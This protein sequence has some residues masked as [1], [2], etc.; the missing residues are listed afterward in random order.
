MSITVSQQDSAW[1]TRLA[2]LDEDARYAA[3]D[4]LQATLADVWTRMH[5][6][7]PRESVV[8]VP[9]MNVDRLAPRASAENQAM[10]ERFLFLL[11]LLRQPRLRLVY[12]TSMP[13]DPQIIEYYLSLLPGVIPSHA[14]SRLS[15]IAV[16]DSSSQPLT[17]KLLARPRVLAEIAT[18]VPDRSRCHLIPYIGTTRERDLSLLLG[19]PMYAADPRL[20]DLGTKS[21][22]RA[23]FA[24]AGV[25][26]PAGSEDLHTVS[27]LVGALVQLHR[28]RP[29]SGWAM[30]K[31]NEG[32][33]GSGNAIVD[34]RGVDAASA[35]I[36]NRVQAMQL[37]DQQITLTAYL[38]RLEERGGIVE[39]RMVGDEIRSPSVQMRVT[40][41]GE[42][43]IISTHDQILGGP[44][45]Q[46]YRGARFPA[47]PAYAATITRSAA[48]VGRLLA[49][50]GMLGRFAVDFIVV[51]HGDE[52]KSHAIEVNLRKGGTTHPYLTL[53]FLTDGR[54]DHEQARFITPSGAERYLVATDHLEDDALRGMRIADLF[55]VVARADLHFDQARQSGIVFHMI[56]SITERGQV[57]MT[58]IADS[59]A[60]AQH[61]FDRAQSVLLTE[62]RESLAPL[63]LPTSC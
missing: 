26:F 61:V 37:T 62:A 38:Q 23:L 60:A 18:H 34:L 51:R 39:E 63:T 57:G 3:F 45:G 47:D 1:G 17:D 29:R 31:L 4:R 30:I 52:W 49:R 25:N 10:E 14:R 22:S 21:G 27:D 16:G 32:T 9:S 11:L 20:R 33:A 59:P 28:R 48:A 55:D 2:D 35:E 46:V 6:D 44:S 13:I 41:V 54:Y 56:S 12:V 24:E 50:K 15:L 58:A 43:E 42:L 19:I 53:Q 40:P 5:T 36:S 7:A 8:V